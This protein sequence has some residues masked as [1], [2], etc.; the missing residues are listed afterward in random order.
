MNAP[1]PIGTPRGEVVL[2]VVARSP[3]AVAALM[4]V[5]AW[6]NFAALLDG[7]HDRGAA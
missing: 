2:A 5:A 4:P 1:R 3:S 7:P 6:P